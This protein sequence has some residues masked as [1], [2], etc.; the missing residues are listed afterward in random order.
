MSKKSVS[1]YNVAIL[2]QSGKV[3]NVR[4]FHR[5]GRTCL[6]PATNRTPHAQ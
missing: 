2:N 3:G 4:Y 5:N 6:R 1:V